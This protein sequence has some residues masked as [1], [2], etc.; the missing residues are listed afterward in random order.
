MKLLEEK[1]KLY[2]IVQLCFADF[3]DF[4]FFFVI[5]AKIYKRNKWHSK[6]AN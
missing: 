1:K 2:F 4:Y 3:F 5:E 6:F